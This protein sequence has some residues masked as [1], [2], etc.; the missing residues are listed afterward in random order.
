MSDLRVYKMLPEQL[1]NE[2]YTH[3]KYPVPIKVHGFDKNELKEQ[4]NSAAASTQ[5]MQ[6]NGPNYSLKIGRTNQKPNEIAQN[7]QQALAHALAYLTYHE[8]HR[9]G[10]AQLAQVSLKV[11]DSPELPIFNQLS[12]DDIAAYNGK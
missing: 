9:L 3:K 11:A 4:L 10:F 6:G 1:G 2:F 8:S 7:A 12:E 5:F